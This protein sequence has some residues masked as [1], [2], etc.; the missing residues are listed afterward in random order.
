MNLVITH[1]NFIIVPNHLREY[2]A[3]A[4]K[5][6]FVKLLLLF[7]ARREVRSHSSE[8]SLQVPSST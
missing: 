7:R 2:K 6:P 3:K 1:V 5:K 4:V 8:S